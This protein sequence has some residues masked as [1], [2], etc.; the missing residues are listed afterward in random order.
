[1]LD[2]AKGKTESSGNAISNSIEGTST[3][4]NNSLESVGNVTENY[5]R[6]ITKTSED[7]K[8]LSSAQTEAAQKSDTLAERFEK[9]GRGLRDVGNK[10]LDAGR[11]V[12]DM[13]SGLSFRETLDAYNAQAKAERTLE[14]TIKS[15]GRNVEQL[16]STY[17]DYA[18]QLQKVS[19]YSNEQVLT[20]TQ[21]AVA[22]GLNERQTK[23]AV[24]SALALA[25]TFNKNTSETIRA[26]SLLE[27][28]STEMLKE[29]IPALKLTTN[30][31]DGLAKAHSSLAAMTEN[32]IA[33]GKTFE[34]NLKQ[35]DNSWNN[36]KESIGEGIAT[37]L[38]PLVDTLKD[39]SGWMSALPKDIKDVTSGG[40][41]LATT[42]GTVA[43]TTGTAILAFKGLTAAANTTTGA[44]AAKIGLLATV[45]YAYYQLGRNLSG[46][47]DAQKEY[48]KVLE[49]SQ[50]LDNKLLSNFDK[51]TAQII[52]RANSI[53][54]NTDKESFIKN[55]LVDATKQLEAFRK[56]V[57]STNKEIQ[58]VLATVKSGSTDFFGNDDK[59]QAQITVARE[60]IKT[61][62]A[63]L[64][65]ARRRVEQLR[66]ALHQ[67]DEGDTF[68]IQQDVKRFEQ[69]LRKQRET[70]GMSANEIKLY[71]LRMQGAKESTVQ[72]TNAIVR[73]NQFLADVD[74]TAAKAKT[75]T[76]SIFEK[77]IELNLNNRDLI[78]FEKNVI[79]LKSEV[80][81]TKF[82]VDL[83]VNSDEFKNA[84]VRADE[85]TQHIDALNN[86]KP[87]KLT[88]NKEQA[89]EELNKLRDQI[90]T[91]GKSIAEVSKAKLFA[92]IASDATRGIKVMERANKVLNDAADVTKRY[93]NPFEKYNQA[94]HELNVLLSTNAITQ[95]TYNRG[96]E[97]AKKN[98]DDVTKSAIKTRESLQMLNAVNFG[99][100]EAEDRFNEFHDKI[101]QQMEA[102]RKLE[103]DRLAAQGKGIPKFT[104]SERAIEDDAIKMAR[105]YAN[106][107][108]ELDYTKQPY[109][110]P[111][112]PPPFQG[113]IQFPQMPTFDVPNVPKITLPNVD[114]ITPKLTIPKIDPLDKEVM[115]R[116]NDPQMNAQAQADSS[117]MRDRELT[118]KLLQSMDKTLS[119]INDKPQTM[120]ATAAIL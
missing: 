46:A 20:L 9:V 86:S 18:D 15:Q 96:V 84:K 117:I 25:D 6:V 60:N 23:R 92:D 111:D 68:K 78:D 51:D 72:M 82:F 37:K 69:E 103:K 118:I 116:H 36:F 2:D 38:M 94:V 97:D 71:D 114:I 35:L 112:K 64:E 75:L 88:I 89:T 57:D 54:S 7:L 22:M 77:G 105:D 17:K 80:D 79:K 85:L 41:L 73:L 47:T 59:E 91:I 56:R 32:T 28:G 62:E 8:R 99:S 100:A 10:A 3:R 115:V 34:G 76:E 109:K 45:G 1:M 52:N 30:Q 43:V 44:L 70:M 21:Q 102:M 39:V 40:L 95:E 48:D 4:V 53:N 26:T 13:T 16:T 104:P 119:D 29:Y 27:L 50:K 113:G 87:T 63:Q 120:L 65:S 19:V 83:R 66:D 55:Q 58:D 107:I 74:K 11:A 49:E 61:Y 98:L 67:I 42:F 14:A 108:H 81:K 110:L 93:M 90:D 5:A 33:R 106:K 101:T 12:S 24:K 31:V